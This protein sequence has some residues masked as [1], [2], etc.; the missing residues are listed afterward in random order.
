MVNGRENGYYEM[1]YQDGLLDPGE[2]LLQIITDLRAGENRGC[3]A[4]RFHGSVAQ[5]IRR[6][7]KDIHRQTGLRQVVLSGGVW[8][9]MFLLAQTAGLLQADG[10]SVLV[11]RQVPAND[12]GLAL[13]QVLI[14]AARL[15]TG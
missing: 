14:A 8:Q 5:V 9:N 6:I 2:A 3:I 12:G 7:C 10:L 1:R 15:Q 4:A 13:G 11:H